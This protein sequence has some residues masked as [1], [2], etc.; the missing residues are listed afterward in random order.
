MNP[1][2]HENRLSGRALFSV[3]ARRALPLLEVP[4]GQTLQEGQHGVRELLLSEEQE[5]MATLKGHQLRAW[6]TSVHRLC[7]PVRGTDVFPSMHDE[8]RHVYLPQPAGRIIV[9][10]RRALAEEGIRGLGVFLA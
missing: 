9:T 4:V 6:N 2:T 5:D 8:D 7:E 10:R 1:V 3:Q